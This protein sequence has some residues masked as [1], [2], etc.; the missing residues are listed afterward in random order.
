MLEH[1]F[2][3]THKKLNVP[4]WHHTCPFC[5]TLSNLQLSVSCV[6]SGLETILGWYEVLSENKLCIWTKTTFLIG[7]D[8][9]YIVHFKAA[10]ETAKQTAHFRNQSLI[11]YFQFYFTHFPVPI[12]DNNDTVKWPLRGLWVT[13]RPNY[14]KCKK[15]NSDH[16]SCNCVCSVSNA[17]HFVEDHCINFL[18]T[19]I[20]RLWNKRR[21]VDLTA[22]LFIKPLPDID[23]SLA[24]CLV[25]I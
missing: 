13:W 20:S 22:F 11:I 23:I 4:C 16:R 24:G 8:H 5:F 21:R 9:N 25:T 14:E 10:S 18:P 19:V 3:T 1:T 12:M 17:W 6:K 7:T 15:H 2:H